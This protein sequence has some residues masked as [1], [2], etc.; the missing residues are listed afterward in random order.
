[1]NPLALAIRYAFDLVTLILFA[2]IIVSYFLN[3]FHP[4][5]RTLD[6]IVDPFLDPIRRVL[7]QTGM[8]D[9]S[10]IVLYL[11]IRIVRMILMSII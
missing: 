9:F 2:K 7:P 1:L 11:L 4:V 10:P 6:S 5:R 8:I 3:P